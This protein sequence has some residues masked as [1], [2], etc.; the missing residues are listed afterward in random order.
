MTFGFGLK[1]LNGNQFIEV[2]ILCLSSIDKT[3]ARG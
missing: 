1:N 3:I 2:C